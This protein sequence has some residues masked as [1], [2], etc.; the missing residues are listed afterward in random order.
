MCIVWAGSEIE[1][2]NSRSGSRVDR[3]E[4]REGGV[5]TWRI[6][7]ALFLPGCGT[8]NVAPAC[9]SWR[10]MKSWCGASGLT[11]RGL[12][13]GP[14][15]GGYSHGGALPRLVRR[16]GADPHAAVC[17]GPVL[18]G[19][20][21]WTGGSCHYTTWSSEAT[22]APNPTV[23]EPRKPGVA[24]VVQEFRSLHQAWGSLPS[25]QFRVTLLLP[26]W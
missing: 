16:E 21:A 13:A 17:A 10:D 14:M 26:F 6:H 22:Q 1:I 2:K 5:V 9:E 25:P 15:T 23:A 18:G 12:S 3:C 20:C 8:S 24:E 4:D 7:G 19:L 11:T